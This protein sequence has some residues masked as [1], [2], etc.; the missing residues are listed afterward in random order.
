MKSKKRG[1]LND[2]FLSSLDGGG[3]SLFY[4]FKGEIWKKSFGNPDLNYQI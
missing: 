4:L 2:R 3:N 1:V